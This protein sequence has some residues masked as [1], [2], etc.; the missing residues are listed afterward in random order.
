MYQYSI[1]L[2]GW[3]IFD[4]I[5][6]PRFLYKFISWWT[7]GLFLFFGLFCIMLLWKF[8]YT[9]ICDCILNYLR[10]IHK[11]W[12]AGSYGNSTFNFLRN[13]QTVLHSRCIILYSQ[14][15]WIRI[16]IYPHLHQHFY[17]FDYRQPK[18]YEVAF[19]MVWF[20]FS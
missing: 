9:I 14:Q 1:P 10:H 7:F 11:E 5:N 3:M 20:A 15:Q 13:H 16:P 12:N 4:C 17:L 19:T 6:M 8:M 18:R 2:Y